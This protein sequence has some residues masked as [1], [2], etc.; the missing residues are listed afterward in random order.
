MP[1]FSQTPGELNIESVVGTDFLCTLNFD[2]NI[3]SYDFEA[4][5][6]LKE[7]PSKV[8]YPITATKSG[9]NIVNLSLSKIQSSEIGAISKRKWYL[10]RLFNGTRQTLIS[11]RF[12]L[13]DIPIGQNNGFNNNVIVSTYNINIDASA[14]SAIGATG[15]TGITG[16]TG[17]Q[18]NAGPVGGQRWAYTGN[19]DTNFN[20]S[21]ATTTNPL[22]YSVN[23]D[24]VTQDPNDYSITSGSPYVLVISSPVPSGSKI[25]ITSLN[26][27]QGATGG[28]G[29]TG[30]GAT[31]A[32][33]AI[34]ATG[35]QGVSGTAAA[36]G[37]R[38][39]YTGNGTQTIFNISGAN[40][41]IASGYLV[42][43]DGI[44][45]DPSYYTINSGSPYTITI[46]SAVPSGSQL[47]IVEIVG[48]I[49]ATGPQG[50][51]GVIPSSV[52]TLTITGEARFGIPVETKATPAITAA[53]LTLNLSTATLFYVTL[54]AATSVIFS[55]PPASPK[56]FSFTLQFVAN[57]TPYS[58]TWPA[59]VRWSGGMQPNITTTNGKIDT[60]TFMT[61][62]GGANWFGIVN[63]QNY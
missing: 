22:G 9:T 39:G 20:I 43:I 57:G 17:A 4:G 19:N 42:A 60:F 30:V 35:P 13:S 6:V 28:T 31:G 63:G 7:F 61:H 36:G 58:V 32:T 49:G 34:G 33:G 11:G 14:I 44:V 8:I 56:V 48:P 23:I 54:N 24:G 45:Q 26:G 27:I 29:A 59:S 21:G 40:S 50:A 52:S 2:I 10:N 18:G 47:V 46:S 5:I 3:S 55:N 1:T 53:S 37:Q 16:A 41:L 38:W 12:E 62:D 15:A 25:V 51:T